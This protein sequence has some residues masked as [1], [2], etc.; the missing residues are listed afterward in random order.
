MAESSKTQKL[1]SSKKR[2]KELLEE[3]KRKKNA[4]L[5]QNLSEN[6]AEELNV[7]NESLTSSKHSSIPEQPDVNSSVPF[8][9]ENMLPTTLFQSTTTTLNNYFT[10]TAN[11]QAPAAFFDNLDQTS[12]NSN[13]SPIT[14]YFNSSEN[15]LNNSVGSENSIQESLN[16][17]KSDD[18][19]SDNRNDGL[20][21]HENDLHSRN[22]IVNENNARDLLDYLNVGREN[23]ENG[24]QSS[25]E[26]IRQLSSQMSELIEPNM[27]FS[28]SITDLE[29]RNLELASQLEAEKLKNQHLLSNIEMYQSKIEKLEKDICEK[30]GESISQLQQE[31]LRLKEE[32]QYHTQ[33]MGIL[34][35]EKTELTANL[36]Q[37]ELTSKQKLAECVEL[38]QRLKASRSRVV[39]L[40]KEV[41]NLKSEKSLQENSDRQ[42]SEVYEKLMA[43]NQKLR[44]QLEESL[45]DLSEVRERLR[46][47]IEENLSL[48]QQNQDVS[49]K[50]SM[51][52]IKIQQLSNGISNE[53]S[54]NLEE[55][56]EE[57]FNLERQVSNLNQ[58]IKDITKERDE[59]NMQYQQYAQQLNIQVANLSSKID[60]LQM[61]KENLLLQEQN[62][63]KHIGELERQLQS[64]QNDRVNFAT[65]KPKKDR[66]DNELIN[67]IQL[68]K[69][70]LQENFNQIS[71][72][73]EMLLKELDAKNDSLAQ[74]ESMVEQL[75]GNQPDS[76]KLLATM[77][78][79]KVAA[80]RAV[81]QNKELKEQMD[82]MQEVFLK[83]NNDKVELTE[84]L[85]NEQRDS[86]EIF[87]KLQKTELHLQR[88]TDAIEIKD[89]ELQN[90]RENLE[91]LNKKVLQQGQ[92]NDRLRHYEAQDHSSYALQSELQEAKQT[93]NKLINE[94]HQLKQQDQ[95]IKENSVELDNVTP[96]SELELLRKQMDELKLKNIELEAELSTKKFEKILLN[97]KPCEDHRHNE[98][99]LSLDKEVA[100]KY[101]EDKVKRT[102]QNIADLTDEKQRLEHLVLQL[103]GETETIG[104]YVALY[105][106]QRS[107]LKQKALEKDQQLKQLDNDREQMKIKL[108]K[109]NYLIS[110]LIKEK[111]IIPENMKSYENLNG[112]IA[113]NDDTD[114]LP[115]SEEITALLS[116]IKTS[117]LVE[118]SDT[119]LHHCSYCSGQLLIV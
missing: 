26:N 90:L 67:Q 65:Q 24:V 11:I 119:N 73:K 99:L 69:N 1:K 29:K 117:N 87:E 6:N 78:S 109:L 3:Q 71:N 42:Q 92:L 102:M 56:Q 43:E 75:R 21:N 4:L 49:S 82:S 64:L 20:D 58:M 14:S 31:N 59:H 52:N 44:E 95:A 76:V 37:F 91:E 68:E 32:L 66:K 55:L 60:G 46:Q 13:T 40:E 108:E 47:N 9:E 115:I 34:V 79:D 33:S 96:G 70:E 22:R 12:V 103:Q 51:A 10:N 54:S 41:N 101:L 39:D 61:E 80:A 116:E 36:A 98:D 62:R 100:M 81:A 93:I 19:L 83:L 86:K 18:F 84:K 77:E 72:E 15:H 63:I 85:T 74:L 89:R 28:N 110:K 16:V 7:T 27:E 114:S 5:P 105:Q 45:Q 53:G 8:S 17:G 57:K 106:H 35:A 38:Q 23:N 104:E 94:I 118:P 88:L 112:Q 50:L 48:Q 107:I 25:V 111:D 97:N 2:Y 30:E 113:R